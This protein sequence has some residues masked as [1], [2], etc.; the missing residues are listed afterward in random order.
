MLFGGQGSSWEEVASSREGEEGREKEIAERAT[1]PT[2]ANDE[3]NFL[4]GSESRPT[5]RI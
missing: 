2:L 3:T 4:S 5:L 1:E